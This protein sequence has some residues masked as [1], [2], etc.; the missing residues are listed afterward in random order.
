MM[1]R[2]WSPTS[3]LWSPR[4]FSDGILQ[5]FLKVVADLFGPLDAEE[6]HQIVAAIGHGRQNLA[7]L[8]RD[9]GGTS[10]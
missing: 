6:A 7:L 3:P 9:S 8:V 10:S 1:V 4:M 5:R 2:A